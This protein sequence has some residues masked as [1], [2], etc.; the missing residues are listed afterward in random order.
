MRFPP[1]SVDPID[2]GAVR[3]PTRHVDVERL[4][5]HAGAV[6]HN[7]VGHWLDREHGNRPDGRANTPRPTVDT[8]RR[9]R[10][11]QGV[12]ST[13]VAAAKKRANP[14]GPP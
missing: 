5:Q 9:A 2:R 8:A 1:T 13:S 14:T 6:L 7:T 11:H 3:H 4:V 12:R 10:A